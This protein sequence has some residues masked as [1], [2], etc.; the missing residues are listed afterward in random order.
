MGIIEFLLPISL[1]LGFGF[2]AAFIYAVR[3]DQFEDCDTPA[4]RVLF[5]PKMKMTLK[6]QDTTETRRE[7]T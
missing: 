5:D 1:F 4:H 2:A 6:P 3:S 7:H